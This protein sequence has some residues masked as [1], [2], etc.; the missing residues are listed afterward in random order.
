MLKKVFCY[1]VALVAILNIHILAFASSQGEVF[2]ATEVLLPTQIQDSQFF[3]GYVFWGI[4]GVVALV[5]LIYIMCNCI[6]R[7]K[8]EKSRIKSEL[9]KPNVVIRQEKKYKIKG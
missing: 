1:F 4:F 6:K 7:Q 8:E 3:W 9:L 5:L 2:Q